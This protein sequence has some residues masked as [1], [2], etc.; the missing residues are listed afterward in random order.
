M[1]ETEGLRSTLRPVGVPALQ[2]VLRRLAAA[3]QPPWLHGEVARRMAERLPVIRQQPETVIDWWSSL[4]ASREWLVET[5]P[6]SRLIA[7]EPD[8]ASRDATAQ[9]LALPWWS[10]RRWAGRPGQAVTE[11]ELG[12][13]AGQLVWANMMLHLAPDVPQLLTQWKNALQTHGVLMFST[14]GPD[15]FASLRQIYAR[16]GWGFPAQEFADM[17]HLG[18]ALV[19]AGYADPVMDQEH[20]TLTWSDAKTLLVELRTWGI[21]AHP[22]RHQGLRNRQWYA[23]LIQALDELK[24]PNGR[25]ALELEIVYGHAIKPPPKVEIEPVSHIPLA[26]MREMVRQSRIKV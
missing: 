9:A 26:Q 7:V 15:S 14:L 4:G 5:Y 10:P 12:G 21:N 22:Q 20:L 6:K 3:G 24:Q 13:N 23:Q 11:A 17:H 25:L 2:R 16:K 18:D 19:K 8:G 1:A